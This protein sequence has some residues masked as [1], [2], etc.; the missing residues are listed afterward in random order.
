VYSL[1]VG[2]SLKCY[3]IASGSLANVLPGGDAGIVIFTS[4]AVT[5]VSTIYLETFGVNRSFLLW[6]ILDETTRPI[7]VGGFSTYDLFFKIVAGL[8][9]YDCMRLVVQYS[10]W[11]NLSNYA[12]ENAGPYTILS[13]RVPFWY[14]FRQDI[15]TLNVYGF[16]APKA[17]WVALLLL[18]LVLIYLEYRRTPR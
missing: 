3:C 14:A 18:T 13:C 6:V 1:L 11:V 15:D 10:I 8:T 9:V 17:M 5:V 4:L 12:Q 16:F 7:L 2:I